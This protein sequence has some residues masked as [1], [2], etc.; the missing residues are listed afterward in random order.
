MFEGTAYVPSLLA[1]DVSFSK[2]DGDSRVTSGGFGGFPG[3]HGN[4]AFSL[5]STTLHGPFAEVDF[6]NVAF[7]AEGAPGAS[8]SAAKT[9]NLPTNDDNA[10]SVRFGPTQYP[11]R[12]SGQPALFERDLDYGVV[13]NTSNGTFTLPAQFVRDM[14]G[15]FTRNDQTRAFLSATAVLPLSCFQAADAATT[16]NSI[17]FDF[18]QDPDGYGLVFDDVALERSTNALIEKE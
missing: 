17:T 5:A 8:G 4:S 13:L 11:S 18:P 6:S 14:P 9:V 1:Y 3:S 12:S 10:I 15:G 7:F 2:R 16:V